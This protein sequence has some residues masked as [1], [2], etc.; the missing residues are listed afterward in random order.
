MA[1]TV[2]PFT[3]IG[4]MLVDELNS[5][6][7]ILKSGKEPRNVALRVRHYPMTNTRMVKQFKGSSHSCVGLIYFEMTAVECPVLLCTDVMLVELRFFKKCCDT[8]KCVPLS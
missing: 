3:P 2:V 1:L 7:K 5:T 6:G 4:L 8:L